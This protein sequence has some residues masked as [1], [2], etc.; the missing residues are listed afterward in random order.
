MHE[1]YVRQ[2]VR[3]HFGQA[4]DLFWST[5]RERVPYPRVAEEQRAR[6]HSRD[7]R[8]EDRGAARGLGGDVRGRRR[9]RTA[10]R[11]ACRAFARSLSI[12]FQ[13]LDDIH[14]Y[15]HSSEWKKA[16]GED[17]AEGKWTH[18]LFRALK[19][20]PPK[21]R[22]RLAAIVGRKESR[23]RSEDLETA[24]DLVKRSGALTACREEA[25]EMVETSW[26]EVRPHFRPSEAKVRLTL[27][28][29]DLMDLK[30]D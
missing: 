24:I 20:L 17:I 30:F 6:I 10:V 15:G 5:E 16:R 11:D 29:K 25:L 7:V 26:K 23:Q 3:A 22:D 27:L 4:M 2:M 18:V 13:I 8:A 14:G 12:G 19:A 28:Y 1:I 21:D 9:S